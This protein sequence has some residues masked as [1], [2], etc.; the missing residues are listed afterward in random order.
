MSGRRRTSWSCLRSAAPRCSGSRSPAPGCSA[1]GCGSDRGWCRPGSAAASRTAAPAGR[2]WRGGPCPWPAEAAVPPPLPPV[3][4]RLRSSVAV[5]L[6]VEQGDADDAAEIAFAR[7]LLG[8][9]GDVHLALLGAVAAEA[10]GIVVF[11][12]HHAQRL[13]ALVGRDLPIDLA[14]G[15]ARRQELAQ[16]HALLPL[17]GPGLAVADQGRRRRDLDLGDVAHLLLQPLRH[18]PREGRGNEALEAGPFLIDEVL[19]LIHDLADRG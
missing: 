5:T 13:A 10:G 3:R 6:V 7:P 1:P 8:I 9:A 2:R 11:R 17:V 14:A 15:P 18:Q 12:H 16:D 19:V 4:H